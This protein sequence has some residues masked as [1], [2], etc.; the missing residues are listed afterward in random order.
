MKKTIDLLRQQQEA[1]R[2]ASEW[3]MLE[4]EIQE[5]LDEEEVEPCYQGKFWNDTTKT[6]KTWREVQRE[7]EKEDNN[8]TSC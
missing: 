3:A 8:T 6:F 4:E 2:G 7:D 5:L 1:T